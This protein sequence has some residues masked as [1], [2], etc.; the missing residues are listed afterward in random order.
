MG[1]RD[2]PELSGAPAQM[3]LKDLRDVVVRLCGTY[4]LASTIELEAVACTIE[5]PSIVNPVPATAI[6]STPVRG[7]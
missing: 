1:K 6:P 3:T 4:P 7:A 2:I 5:H